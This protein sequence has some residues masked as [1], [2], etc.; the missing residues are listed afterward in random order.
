[1]RAELPLIAAAGGRGRQLSGAGARA[2]AEGMVRIA[3]LAAIGLS[4]IATI[5][6]RF[7]GMSVPAVAVT[8]LLLGLVLGG[9]VLQLFR[10]YRADR[11]ASL[12]FQLPRVLAGWTATVA[13]LLG[14]LYSFKVAHDLSRLWV[15]SWFLAGLASLLAV[16]VAA[17]IVLS[18]RDVARRLAVVGLGEHLPALLRRLGAVGPAFQVAAALDLDQSL[19]GR[20]PRGIVPLHGFADLERCVYDGEIDQIVLALPARDDG[21]L[22]RTLRT[23]RHLPVDVSWAPELPEARVPILGIIQAGDVPLVRLLE[24]PLDGWRYVLK[25]LEDR[26]LAG[27]VLLFTAPVMLAIALAVKLD[28]PGPVFYRQ[29]RHGFSKQP[30]EV[31]KFRSMYVDRCDAPDAKTVRQATRDDPR[32]TRVGRFLRRTSLDE[33]PQLINVLKGEM[34]LVGPRPHAMAHDDHYARLIDDYLGRHRVKPGIT[35]W[36]QV[37]GFRGETRTTEEMRR[38]IELDLEYIDNWSLWAD[39][40]ILARTVFVGFV[41]LN[42]H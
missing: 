8:A 40:R 6:W 34:S 37:N 16:R 1:M 41:H 5:L 36:A 23:L 10:L 38:R 9:N 12:G 39:L 20:W 32:V 24:R 25:S 35:G 2:L 15:G 27:L 31:L 22:E 18:R 17:R 7:A 3:D 33:L 11:L 4:G 13:V 29:K 30:I 26:I 19:L 42:A 14:V 21:L 28:S